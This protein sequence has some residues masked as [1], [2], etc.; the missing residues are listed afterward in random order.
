MIFGQ[1]RA[2]LRQMYAN[3]WRKHEAGELLSP[4]EAQIVAVIE[5]H[6]EYRA[7]VLD[8]D[9]ERSYT[10]EE[11]G[12]NPFLHLGLHLAL[13]DQVATDRPPG[14]RDVFGRIAAR[15]GDRLDAEHRAIDC[16][17]ETLWEAQRAN[18]LPDEQAYLERLRRLLRV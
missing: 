13:R 9:L 12:T 17:A 5:D 1:D 15:T 8:E 16:L 10:P 11:G 2:E 4:L 6:P 18:A 3:A 7:A 14:I